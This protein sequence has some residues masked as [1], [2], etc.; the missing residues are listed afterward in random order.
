MAAAFPA[1]GAGCGRVSPH[2]LIVRLSA[3]GDVV[4]SSGLIPALRARWPEARIS[5]LTQAATVPLLRH[6]P[7]LAEVIIWPREAWQAL[8]RQRQWVGLWRAVRSFRTELRVR[9]FDLV[10]DPQGLLKSGLLG[11]ISGAPRRVGLNPK[12]GSQWLLTETVRESADR[13]PDPI[14]SHEYRALARHLGAPEQAFRLD[15]AVGEAPRAQARRVLAE[16]GLSAPPVALCPF[17]TRPQKHWF[18]DRWS[19]LA[20]ARA[21]GGQK[22]VL[23]GGPGDAE[24]G[25]GIVAA[26]PGLVSLVGR[27]KLDESVAA[28][29]ECQLLIGVD[30]GMTHMGT[31]LGVPTLALF[32]STRPY[33]NAGEA[34]STVLYEPRACSPCHRH[35]TCGGRFDCMRVW[36]LDRVMAESAQLLGRGWPC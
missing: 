3:I 21:A 11:W 25:A 7:E 20:Q 4:L 17:T 23:L 16:A 32:G 36:E 14:I 1:R 33:L 5:W 28:I 30:T 18:E 15:L 12:E 22:P 27:L 8:A 2:I 34:R 24:A 26:A 6:N 9:R 29:A 10:V 31:A 19:A 13:L 35:P